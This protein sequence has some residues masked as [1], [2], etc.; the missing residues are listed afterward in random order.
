MVRSTTTDITGD[1]GAAFP[2][3]L[4]LTNAVL[5]TALADGSSIKTTTT[6]T[7][8]VLFQ[9]YDVDGSAYKTFMTL[10]AG[11]TPSLSIAQPAGATLHLDEAGLPTVDVAVAA[12]TDVTDAMVVTL[13]VEDTLGNAIGAVHNL[14]FWFSDDA[15]GAGFSSTTL[16]GD[17]TTVTGTEQVEHTTKL[18]YDVLT[19]TT[20]IAVLQVVASANPTELYACVKN[21]Y[22]GQVITTVSGTNWEGA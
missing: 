16:S 3:G 7:D 10:T 9:A 11:N 5:T 18:H 17:T 21:P 6:D 20:G 22:T 8:N 15:T 4:T 2:D 13:T 14:E 1:I 12:S 19:A